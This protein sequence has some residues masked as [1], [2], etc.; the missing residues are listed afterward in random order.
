M[1]Y[2]VHCDIVDKNI[3]Q[4]KLKME[5]EFQMMDDVRESLGMDAWTE[6]FI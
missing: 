6:V 2:C 1:C 4:I 5:R 3:L